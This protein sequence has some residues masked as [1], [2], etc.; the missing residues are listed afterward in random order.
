LGATRDEQCPGHR[1]GLFVAYALQSP[2]AETGL[3][4]AREALHANI[5]KIP[6][7]ATIAAGQTV[8]TSQEL[9]RC[10]IERIGAAEA[11]ARRKIGLPPCRADLAVT[12]GCAL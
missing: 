4:E 7:T 10:V 5:A 12:A 8:D 3:R 11:F 2:A 6:F 1:P 9:R